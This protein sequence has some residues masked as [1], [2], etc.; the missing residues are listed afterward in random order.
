MTDSL[1]VHSYFAITKGCYDGDLPSE[2]C[3]ASG[4]KSL[5]LEGVQAGEECNTAFWDPLGLLNRA[6]VGSGGSLGTIPACLWDMPQLETLHLSGNMLTGSLPSG[7]SAALL[8]LRDLSLSFNELT[9][10]FSCGQ[11]HI[12]SRSPTEFN[13]S[14]RDVNN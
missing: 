8:S 7:P 10:E 14:N 12:L 5:V 2:V 13:H 6:Y 9:G 3:G 1:C 11:E 4:L